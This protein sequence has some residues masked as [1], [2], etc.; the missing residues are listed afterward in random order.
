MS[1]T[2]RP[3]ALQGPTQDAEEA[4]KFGRPRMPGDPMAPIR[5][6]LGHE[7]YSGRR[8]IVA[9]LQF[10]MYRVSPVPKGN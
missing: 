6:G 5:P 10:A 7:F 8:R 2:L 3:W 9:L 4:V 1:N